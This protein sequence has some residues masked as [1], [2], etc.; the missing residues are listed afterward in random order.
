M[1]QHEHFLFY[2][3]STVFKVNDKTEDKLLY[4]IEPL[5]KIGFV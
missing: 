5:T 1:L 3:K 4:I 2:D